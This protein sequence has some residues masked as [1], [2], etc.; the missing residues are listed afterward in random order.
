MQGPISI[1]ELLFKFR[2]GI[3][4]EGTLVRKKGMTGW[5]SIQDC[6][7][8]GMFAVI[9]LDEFLDL[10]NWYWE[11]PKTKDDQGPLPA[12]EI[13]IRYTTNVLTKESR[14]RREEMDEMRP[15]GDL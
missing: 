6:D 8:E 14:V 3:L 4:F 1:G 9:D 5:K 11:D 7:K 13:L 10:D 12:K 15:L 2:E